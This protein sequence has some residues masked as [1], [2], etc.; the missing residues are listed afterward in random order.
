[1]KRG[2]VDSSVLVAIAFE[3]P[4]AQDLRSRLAGFGELLASPLLEAELASALA[5][6]ESDGTATHLLEALRFLHPP[7]RLTADIEAALDAG[8]LRCADLFH[9][10]SALYASPKAELVFLSL[11]SKQRDVAARLGF[12]VAP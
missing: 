7:R 1:L 6:E 11:D 5:R 9:V 2:F 4:G 3:E 12:E 10:A 8:A